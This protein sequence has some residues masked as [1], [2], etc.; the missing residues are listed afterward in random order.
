MHEASRSKKNQSLEHRPVLTTAMRSTRLLPMVVALAA[1]AACTDTPTTTHGIKPVPTTASGSGT[2]VQALQCSVQ[3]SARAVSCS[4]LSSGSGANAD[5]IVGGQG[6]FVQLT[7]SNIQYNSGTGIFSFDATVENLISQPMGTS[8]GTTADANGVRVFFNDGPNVTAGTGT[9]TVANNDGVGTFITANQPY[10][11]YSGAALSS[12]HILLQNETSSAKNWQLAVSPTVTQFSFQVLVSTTVPHPMGFVQMSKDSNFVNAGGTDVITASVRNFSGTAA[13]SP[14]PISWNSVNPSVATVDGSGNVTAVAPGTTTITATSDTLVGRTTIQVCPVFGSVGTTVVVSGANAA[15]VCMA[16][17]SGAS[18][19]YVAVPFNT[20]TSASTA[21]SFIGTGITAAA[22]PPNPNLI[23]SG[24]HGLSSTAG[25]MTDGEVAGHLALMRRFAADTRSRSRLGQVNSMVSSKRVAPRGPSRTITFGASYD[26]GDPITLDV[27]NACLGTQDQR[28]GIVKAHTAHAIVAEESGVPANGFT[29]ADYL[30]IAQEFDTTAFAIDN[31]YFTPPLDLARTGAVVI[32]FTTGVNQLNAPGTSSPVYGYFSPKDFHPADSGPV[33][34]YT[35]NAGDMLYMAVPDP[36][37]SING[38]VVTVADMRARTMPLLTHNLVHLTR[39]WYRAWVSNQATTNAAFIPESPWL[40]EAMAN[41]ANELA[42]FKNA[43]LSTR[44]NVQASTLSGSTLAQ[45][46]FDSQQAA[47]FARL[48]QW[49]ARPDTTGAYMGNPGATDFSP[50][51][52]VATT[53][54]SWAFLRYSAD[55]VGGT[56]SAFW[57][58]L[59]ISADTGMTNLGN[60]IGTSPVTWA[61]DFATSMYTDDAVSGV[62][63]QYSD[64]TWN[65]RSVFAGI[66]S[67]PLQTTTLSTGVA[68]PITLN[69]GATSYLRYGVANNAFGRLNTTQGGGAPAA[70]I[71]LTIIRTK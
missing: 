36:T 9:A 53:G 44:T 25:A 55:R 3:I 40:E 69:F 45:N 1:F 31:T 52:N 12:D 57:H 10:F 64:A 20:A 70:N 58:A 11:Q 34:C 4:P 29:D 65:Y 22:G 21:L 39:G 62:A 30:A 19:E 71:S 68:S 54:A 37:G 63:A 15:S 6:Q 16:G 47:N 33:G 41:A 60:V 51:E 8:D 56:E 17:G 66:G 32:F 46:A 27:E 50:T 28:G 18:A 2:T 14:A 48:G 49:L 38:N 23:P 5:V 42:F 13:S 67:F 24:R 61:R 43:G 35:S 26:P 7:S 59:S